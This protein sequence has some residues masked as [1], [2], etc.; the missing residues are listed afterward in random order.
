MGKFIHW[1]DTMLNQLD[2]Q[3]YENYSALQ[4]HTSLDEALEQQHVITHSKFPQ[5]VGQVLALSTFLE[6]EE[7]AANIIFATA[8]KYWGRLSI[9]TAQSMET[10]GFNIEQL[11]TQLDDFFY[12]QQGK[13][14]FFAHLAVHNSMNW[15]QFMQILLQREVTVASDT[16]LKEIYLYEW[17]ARYMPHII[18]VTQQSFWY[19]LLAKKINSLLLQLPLHTI[20]KM[21][22]LQ[23]QWY[24]ALQEA[25]GHEKNFVIWRERIVTSTYEFVNRNTAAYS[26]AQKQWLLSLVFL[27]SQSCE[28]NAKQIEHYIQDIWQRDEDK[29][30]LTDTEKVA[31]HFV[32]LKIAVY[33]ANEDKVITISDYL[34]TKERLQRNAIKIMLHYD[35]LPSYPPSP[36]QIIKCYD[37]NYMEFMYYVVIQA[38]FKQKAYRAIM[39]LVKKDALATCDRIQKLALGQANYEALPLQGGVSHKCLQQSSA[40]IER[41]QVACEQTQHK[42][43][44]KRLRMLQEKLSIQMR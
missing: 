41:I 30:P 16:A 44:A 18:M 17:Q 11:H 2:R 37:K 10:V 38:L 36:S 34:L 7:T 13:E 5:A 20:P 40:H 15:H 22:Q 35:V 19:A 31:L 4:P 21:A 39:Q 43:L 25:Y 28:R 27:L 32:Q 23:Q 33:Y 1:G 14:N 24:N 9:P 42:A 6:D 8:R 26:I 12:S 29:L 3:V